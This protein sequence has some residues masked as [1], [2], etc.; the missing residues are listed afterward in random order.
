MRIP[1]AILRLEACWKKLLP[2]LSAK[3]LKHWFVIIQCGTSN[4]IF[5]GKYSKPVSF[6]L[7]FVA[8]GRTLRALK[9]RTTRKKL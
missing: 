8:I 7:P 3:H 5:V 6:P 2:E 9:P 4:G 1:K